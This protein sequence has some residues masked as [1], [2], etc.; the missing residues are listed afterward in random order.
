MKDAYKRTLVEKLFDKA[1]KPVKYGVIVGDSGIH[2]YWLGRDRKEQYL[3]VKFSEYNF[4]KPI[5]ISCIRD[6]EQSAKEAEFF[7][8]QGKHKLGEPGYGYEAFNKL[9]DDLN[10]NKAF[11][12]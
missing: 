9:T 12:K 8:N 11:I 1:F 7:L 10:K 6:A 5:P 2:P 4:A 3:L